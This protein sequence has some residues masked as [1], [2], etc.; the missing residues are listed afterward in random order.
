MDAFIRR[1]AGKIIGVL[2]G[3]DRLVFRGTLRSLAVLGGMKYF[4]WHRQVLL[5]DFGRYAEAATRRLKEASLGVA[6][7]AGRPVVYLPSAGTDKEA[8][9][10]RIAEQDGVRRGLICVLTSVEP[11]M[12]YDIHRNRDAKRLELVIRQ[13]KCLF[14]YHYFIHPRFGFMHARIQTWFPFSIQVC[15]NGREFLAQAMDRKRLPYFRNGNCFP[16]LSSV[17]RAQ[18]LMD[19]L[20]WTRWPEELNAIARRL[21]P[22]HAEIFGD[23]RT[24]YY[25]SAYQSEWAT[26]VMF[27]RPEYLAAIYPRLTRHA[28]ATFSSPDVMRFLGRKL[29][30]HFLGEVVSDYKERPEGVRV[31]HRVGQNSI[32]MYDKAGRI[33]RV[34]TTVNQPREFKVFR[35]AEGDPGGQRAWR[36]LRKGVADLRRRARVSDDSNRRYLDALAAVD[37]ARSVGET[38]GEV[39]RPV[40][41]KGR[42]VRAL[43]PGTAEDRSLFRAVNAGEFCVNG[44]RNRD[45]Q[46]LL[47]P[48]SAGT[49]RAGAR[50]S[51]KLRLLRAHGLIRKVPRTHC[52]RVTEKGRAV[53]TAALA[54]H[55]VTPAQL[56]AA[57][58]A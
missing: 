41:W 27:E 6:E 52:Y 18:R 34:E 14:L 50:M 24:E 28:I 43:H 36:V 20:L 10:R 4:L 5:K 42:R 23:Y 55:D 32:K 57:A 33:L 15:M 1:Y 8:V 25:W 31:K 58:A 49:R 44:F 9:A 35:K 7:A 53:M 29:T 30:G 51:R 45:L 48:A 13:R 38:V 16:R 2:R 12:G 56:N 21:N 22:A 11:C 39:C 37:T 47:D 46:R 54:A 40:R 17:P 3:F 26:D 19:G